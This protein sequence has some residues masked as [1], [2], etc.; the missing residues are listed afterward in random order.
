MSLPARS[1]RTAIMWRH[2]HE[3]GG[4]AVYTRRIVG[5]LLAQ[6]Q[7]TQYYVFVPEDVRDIGMTAANLEV[8]PVSASSRWTWDQMAV[9]KVAEECHADVVFNPKL[10]VPLRGGFKTAFML[11]GMEQFVQAGVF[12]AID[13]LYVQFMMPRY[14]HHADLILC[15]S[16]TVKEEI[17]ERLGVTP[18]KILVTPHGLDQRFT[19]EIEARQL[20]AVREKY[21]LPKSYLLFVG[22]V[23]PL[24]NLPTILQSMAHLNGS[25]PHKLVLSGFDR[26]KVDPEI[27]AIDRLGLADQVIRLGWVADE[28]QPAV[29]AMASALLFPSLYE[30]FGLPVIEAMAAGCPVIT[31][32]GGALPEVAGDAALI[33]EPLDPVGLADAIRRVTSD[34]QMAQLLSERGRQRVRAFDWPATA[35]RVRDAFVQLT[36]RQPVEPT[37]EA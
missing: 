11:H 12:P 32:T 7:D 5:H 9:P 20:Q 3:R 25:I 14:C 1:M 34:R 26:W 22:G 16:R 6:D 33:V 37:G 35:R 15:P 17:V 23:T 30:G 8:V 21:D 4:V 24:K 18:Q 2:Y 13:R 29:Y 19:H 36:Q 27:E 10:S 28:D 31:S